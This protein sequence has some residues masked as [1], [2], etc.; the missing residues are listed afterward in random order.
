[1]IGNVSDTVKTFVEEFDPAPIGF[2]AFD[3]DYYSSTKAALQLLEQPHERFLPRVFC[4]FNDIV[5]P[6]FE[7]HCEFEASNN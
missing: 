2:I 3:L 7:L 1:M 4:Y 6:P 5:G